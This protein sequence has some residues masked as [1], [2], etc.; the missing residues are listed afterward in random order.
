MVRESGVTGAIGTHACET[1]TNLDAT[2]VPLWMPEILVLLAQHVFLRPLCP[3]TLLFTLQIFKT[4][5]N[6]GCCEEED[7]LKLKY[8]YARASR[9]PARVVVN[10]EPRCRY[11]RP[12]N[13]R[14]TSMGH[15]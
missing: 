2:D 9:G 14:V 5:L 1:N 4:D 15:G 10:A 8:V 11:L 7:N 6:F 3:I 13:S 12:K